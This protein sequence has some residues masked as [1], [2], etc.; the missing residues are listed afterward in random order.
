MAKKRLFFGLLPDP[1]VHSQLTE[2]SRS[3]PILQGVEPVPNKN[4]HI[5]LQYLGN[6][7]A[8]ERK[9][10]EKKM[11]QTYVQSFSLRLD[12]YGFFKRSQILWLGCSTY[13]RELTRLVNHLKSIAENCGAATEERIYKPHVTLFKNVPKADFPD[14]PFT[15]SWCATEFHLLESVTDDE[16]TRYVSLAKHSFLKE[17]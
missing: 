10:I 3:F 13:P 12:L 2:L 4:L 11:A 16:G 15:I 14:I 5:T 9:C 7:E 8:S 1:E 17:E 6:L